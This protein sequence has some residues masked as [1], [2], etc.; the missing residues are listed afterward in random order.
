MLGVSLLARGCYVFEQILTLIF[1]FGDVLLS[2]DFYLIRLWPNQ[3]VCGGTNIYFLFL[4]CSVLR[5]KRPSGLQ[6]KVFNYKLT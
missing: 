4:D 1:R 2:S 6:N 3:L 5:R